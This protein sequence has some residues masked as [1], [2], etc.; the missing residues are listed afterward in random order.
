MTD[1]PEYS[2]MC[3][4]LS[5]RNLTRKYRWYGIGLERYLSE[6]FSIARPG[7]ATFAGSHRPVAHQPFCFSLTQPATTILN[8]DRLESHDSRD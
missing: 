6:I 8:T 7:M 4:D 2:R 1:C 5:Q 3:Q